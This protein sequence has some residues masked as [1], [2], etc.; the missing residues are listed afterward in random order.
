MDI[1]TVMSE[2][3]A[4]KRARR[5]VVDARQSV[6]DMLPVKDIEDGVLSLRDGSFRI[7]VD[8]PAKNYSIYSSEQMRQEAKDVSVVLSSITCPFAII[9]YAKTI[10]LQ[11]GLIELEQAIDQARERA[12]GARGEVLDRS[13]MVR[14]DLLERHMLPQALAEAARAEQ[15]G[16]TNVIAFCFSSKTPIEEAQRQVQTFCRI[17]QDKTK[18][19]PRKLTSAEVTS[20]L[21]E[22]LTPSSIVSRSSEPGSVVLPDAWQEVK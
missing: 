8:Y 9:K 13:S 22:W 12:I 2:R 6:Q 17:A 11:E 19:M 3:K 10:E 18:V 16:I 5:S 15:V 7:F 21:G 20:L 4:A 1:L 14:L